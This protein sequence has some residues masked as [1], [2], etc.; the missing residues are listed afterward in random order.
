MEHYRVPKF[1]VNLNVP[2]YI[3][4]FNPTGTVTV[5]ANYLFGSTLDGNINANYTIVGLDEF[6]ALKSGTKFLDDFISN[7]I[8]SF[9]ID[10]A[11][12]WS[13]MNPPP[14]FMARLEVW[15]KAGQLGLSTRT[16]NDHISPTRRL[17]N[18]LH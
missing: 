7:G 8:Y 2:K 17:M 16:N 6:S 14:N 3:D 11:S 5:N 1:E 9:D 4:K 15:T 18:S 12:I 10:F 13:D